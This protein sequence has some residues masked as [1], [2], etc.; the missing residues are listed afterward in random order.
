MLCSFF[1]TILQVC[2]L[3]KWNEQ[4][5]ILKD[6]CRGLV[7]LHS[8][9][10]PRIHG[11]I[12]RKLASTTCMLEP[13]YKISFV[14]VMSLHACYNISL[15]EYTCTWPSFKHAYYCITMLLVVL[16]VDRAKVLLDHHLTAKIGDFGIFTTTPRAS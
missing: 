3:L 2:P 9:N 15:M 16:C 8:S 10:P 4:S 13:L 1:S 12:R 7:W 11:D 6:V 5:R 14:H